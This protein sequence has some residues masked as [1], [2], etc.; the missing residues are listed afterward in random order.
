MSSAVTEHVTL[1]EE[2]T[3][4]N[5]PVAIW[6]VISAEAETIKY[7]DLL[8]LMIKSWIVIGRCSMFYKR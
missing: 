6:T 2:Q 3:S 8:Y 7:Q 1:N 5:P 4:N